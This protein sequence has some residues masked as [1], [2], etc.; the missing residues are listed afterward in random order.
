MLRA[1]STV[2]HRRLL[3][4]RYSLRAEGLKREASRPMARDESADRRG[5]NP[6]RVSLSTDRTL[7]SRI[8]LSGQ[9]T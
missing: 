7:Q 9:A 3:F 2:G 5:T 8:D 1:S 4:P 6:V